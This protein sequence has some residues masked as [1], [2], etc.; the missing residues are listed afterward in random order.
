MI[1][2]LGNCVISMCTG[3]PNKVLRRCSAS[4]PTCAVSLV[5]ERGKAV[6]LMYKALNLSPF[7][8]IFFIPVVFCYHLR[9]TTNIHT[10]TLFFCRIISSCVG[11]CAQYEISVLLAS[12][13][14]NRFSSQHAKCLVE[15]N[16][17]LHFLLRLHSRVG[18]ALTWSEWQ[19]K[20]QLSRC[21]S[22]LE[23]NSGNKH[24]YT[25]SWEQIVSSVVSTLPEVSP[26][27]LL[28]QGCGMVS[29]WPLVV[30]APSA[31]AW[32]SIN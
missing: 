22:S 15:R 30:C 27:L 14:S 3:A 25:T 2:S 9:I 24:I 28:L 13:C 31:C 12:V 10:C 5:R 7:K 17:P 26:S 6:L 29:E 18:V 8:K 23:S 1:D 19:V 4:S 32:V 20:V 16:M 21:S 11:P